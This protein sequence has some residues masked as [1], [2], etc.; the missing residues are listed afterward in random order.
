LD[1]HLNNL[2]QHVEARLPQTAP[3]PKLLEPEGPPESS[4]VAKTPAAPPEAARTSK[5]GPQLSDPAPQLTFEK[6]VENPARLVGQKI[7]QYIVQEHIGSGGSGMVYRAAH[8]ALGQ[9]VCIKVFYP[10]TIEGTDAFRNI[11]RGVRG[12]AAMNHPHVIKVFDLE[13]IRLP[14]A[15]SLYLV[16]EFVRGQALDQWSRSIPDS[17][18]AFALRMQ[19]ALDVTNTL[20]A[21]HSCKYIDEVGFEQVGVL[22]GDIKPANI[23]VR[24]NNSPVL[25][26]FMMLDVQRL[27]DARF[28]SRQ[29]WHETSQTGAFGTPGFMAPEQERDGIVTVRTDVY[30]LGI[31]LCHLF[32]PHSDEPT[33]TLTGAL[34]ERALALRELLLPMLATPDMRP[35]DMDEV[36]RGLTSIIENQKTQEKAAE[37]VRTGKSQEPEPRITAQLEPPGGMNL[38]ERGDEAEPIASPADNPPPPQVSPQVS[39]QL[40]TSQP[41]RPVEKINQNGETVRQP[42]ASDA[43]EGKRPPPRQSVPVLGSREVP[44]ARAAKAAALPVKEPAPRVI[45]PAVKGSTLITFVFAFGGGVI[46]L[47][48]SLLFQWLC[49]HTRLGLYFYFFEPIMTLR[50]T[51]FGILC[52]ITISEWSRPKRW[53][54]SEPHR[55]RAFLVHGSTVALLAGS[56]TIPLTLFDAYNLDPDSYL[57]YGGRNRFL[58]AAGWFYSRAT[59]TLLLAFIGFIVG[60]VICGLRLRREEKGSTT[61]PARRPSARRTLTFSIVG[62]FILLVM[63]HG[64][65]GVDHWWLLTLRDTVFGALLGITISEWQP[66]ALWS[67]RP[68]ERGKAFIAHIATGAAIGMVLTGAILSSISD[69]YR[70]YFPFYVARPVKL[71][72]YGAVIGACVFAVRLIRR[73][74]GDP[75]LI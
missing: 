23:I 40:P 54:V 5:A 45:E 72:V 55:I 69:F 44:R 59:G 65:G 8:A 7:G 3:L 25:L 27:L 21:A 19:M 31:T 9:T 51:V 53:S 39:T 73:S 48:A 20:A 18:D 71:G 22:H 12:L 38:M 11:A 33:F 26:D 66:S 24:E 37:D 41:A 58:A 29:V 28:K 32:F 75:N 42:A 60:L 43:V 30:G 61:Q 36:A 46:L 68:G 49:S 62:A 63:N 6:L 10:L 52:G 70:Q 35:K 74:I 16:M 15:F 47:I 2:V 4:P 56:M 1:S 13:Q 67:I 64:V 14:D 50:D 57:L 34:D 17:V